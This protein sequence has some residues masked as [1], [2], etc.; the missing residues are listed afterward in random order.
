MV[1]GKAAEFAGLV[2]EHEFSASSGWLGRWKA[3]YSVSFRRISGEAKDSDGTGA[4]RWSTTVLPRLLGDYRPEDLFNADETGLMYKA[5]R[6]GTLA[7]RGEAVQGGATQKAR[8]TL[9][10][11]ANA[12]GT[13]CFCSR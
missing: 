7:E 11:I 13:D 12:S 2:D 9:L 4:A 6:R 10:C 5:M 3:R 1:L 8:L